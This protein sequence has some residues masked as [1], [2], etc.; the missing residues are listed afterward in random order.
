MKPADIGNAV[1][2]AVISELRWSQ[3]G[4]RSPKIA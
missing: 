3:A 2:V 4:S 1:M